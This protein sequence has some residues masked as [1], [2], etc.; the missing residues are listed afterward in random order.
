LI[1]LFFGAADGAVVDQQSNR[2]SIFNLLEELS[3]PGFPA[4]HTQ[5][6][7]IAI[8]DRTQDEPSEPQMSIRIVINQTELITTPIVP[9]FGEF[10]RARLVANLSG[11][12]IPEPGMLRCELRLNDDVISTWNVPVREV[13]PAIP[14]QTA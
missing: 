10:T 7:I 1:V 8:L 4:M 9:S 2:I 3:A 12:A 5:M 14:P 13:A 6:A 11:L